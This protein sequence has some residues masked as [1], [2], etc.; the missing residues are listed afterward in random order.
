MFERPVDNI[1]QKKIKQHTIFMLKSLI[2][3]SS[4]PVKA[5]DKRNVM[6]SA[7]SDL[8]HVMD[9]DVAKRMFGPAKKA[10][11]K[12]GVEAKIVRAS[13][14]SPDVTG[15]YLGININD[16]TRLI[17]ERKKSNV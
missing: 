4:A 14:A 1:E 17:K 12:Y 6:L 11:E 3:E 7:V 13:M 5:E 2:A 15:F 8:N 10:V 9:P 16:L